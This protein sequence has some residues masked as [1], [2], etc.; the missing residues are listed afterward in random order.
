[1]PL[2]VIVPLITE[3]PSTFKV[4]TYPVGIF[5]FQLDVL[6]V[7][8]LSN[9]INEPPINVMVS[10]EP[11]PEVFAISVVRAI[12]PALMVVPPV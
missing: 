5:K 12:E 1:M 7:V 9:I 8:W 3:R 4:P 6:S 2:P 10:A 11:S